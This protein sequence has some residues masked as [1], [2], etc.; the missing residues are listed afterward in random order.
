[1][2]CGG[3]GRRELVKRRNISNIVFPIILGL[4]LCVLVVT[5]VRAPH[6]SPA[7]NGSSPSD[8]P[9]QDAPET[10]TP[11]VPEE[12]VPGNAPGETEPAQEQSEQP[13]V[14]SSVS[15]PEGTPSGSPTVPPIGP[16][17]EPTAETAAEDGAG[18]KAGTSGE[19]DAPGIHGESRETERP[20]E[21]GNVGGSVEEPSPPVRRIA[22]S[23]DDFSP[24]IRKKIASMSTHELL[25]Q[26]F[27]AAYDGPDDTAKYAA[28]YGFAGYL[29]FA[30]DYE[31]ET[32][33]SFRT[34]V[35]RVAAASA[36]PPFIAVDEEGGDVTRISRFRAYR[37][38]PFLSPREI[39]E[40]GG[41]DLIRS[42]A[43]EKAELCKKLGVNCNFAPVADISVDPEDYMFSRSLGQDAETTS[44]I[45]ETIVGVFNARGVASSVKHFPGYGNV[46]DTHKALAYDGR[47][48]AELEAFDLIP[49]VR[50]MNTGVPSVMVSHIITAL[51]PERPASVSS[52][53]AAYIRGNMGYDGVLITD[54]MKMRGILDFCTSGNGSL[55]A[56]LAGYDLIC[57]S[58]W[59]EQFPVVLAAV[60]DGT[61]SRERLELSAA[62]VLRMKRELGIW[63][64]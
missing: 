61:I 42:D 52:K 33:A 32:P 37:R 55:E 17:N 63:N 9:R 24:E 12:V 41:I 35:D 16:T 20:D 47:S 48:L 58:N 10:G 5:A 44:R 40:T 18:E 45:V 59:E 56:I 50:A 36:I 38:F 46:S 25:A 11:G 8:A 31:N 64:P 53:V 62:R 43:A 57:C 7:A 39:Y 6:A 2:L 51:D 21:P 22:E 27:I 26:M 4:L 60:E 49:F 15:V 34:D 30:E 54:D 1:M 29:T 14:G 19:P 3:N 13:P 23:L 28:Q